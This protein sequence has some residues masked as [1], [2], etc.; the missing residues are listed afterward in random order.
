MFPFPADWT[1]PPTLTL[2]WQTTVEEALDNSE[3]RTLLRPVERLRQEFTVATNNAPE[4]ELMQRYLETRG[5]NALEVPIWNYRTE[6]VG[7]AMEIVTELTVRSTA[8][9]R[10][11]ET[12]WCYDPLAPAAT[13]FYIVVSEIVSPTMIRLDT[14][15]TFALSDGAWLVPIRLGYI[16]AQPAFDR[17]TDESGTYAVIFEQADEESELSAWPVP[18]LP[19]FQSRPLWTIAPDWTT[20]PKL[21]LMEEIALQRLG[22]GT[23]LAWRKEPSPRRVLTLSFALWGEEEIAQLLAYLRTMQG[24]YSGVWIPTFGQDLSLLASIYPEENFATLQDAG[25]GVYLTRFPH[26]AHGAWLNLTG[27]IVPFTIED[28]SAPSTDEERI[29]VAYESPLTHPLI[30]IETIG[31]LLLYARLAEDAVTLE[32]DGPECLR[33]TLRFVELPAVQSA[34][35]TG[36]APVWLY[37]FT[38]GENDFYLTSYP[39]PLEVGALTFVPGNLNHTGISASLDFFDEGVKIE[40]ATGDANSFF[41][42]WLAG[43]PPQS[44]SVKIYQALLPAL[45]VDLAAPLYSGDIGKVTYAEEGKITL[46]LSS[47][48]R[49]GESKVPRVL[50]GSRCNWRFGGAQCGVN[51]APLTVTGPISAVSSK[52]V[53]VPAIAGAPANRFTNGT[54]TVNNLPRLISKHDGIRLYLS[55]SFPVTVQPGQSATVEP[56]CDRAYGTCQGYGNQLR[57]GGFPHI[58]TY[59]PQITLP[60]PSQQFTNDSSK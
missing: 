37:H 4:T 54:I 28:V 12:L 18:T 2:A 48:F 60:P 31:S 44:A 20:P 59:N 55:A 45:V 49:L 11:G 15:L 17:E 40:T 6:L 16:E 50:L 26:A 52:F 58:P 47:I 35:E 41:R 36:E 10:V 22:F 38:Q 5:T 43:A 3:R 9:L 27:E 39:R 25:L 34:T 23:P 13:P 14:P 57:F 32:W 33:V 1:I 51:L 53:D 29:D 24:R 56:A 21:E 42:Q 30:A 46:E 8:L 7:E 19:T